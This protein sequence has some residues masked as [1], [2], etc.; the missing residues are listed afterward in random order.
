MFCRIFKTL[1]IS[2]DYQPEELNDKITENN[3]TFVGQH[4]R[5]LTSSSTA[6]LKCCKVNLC[7]D[8]MF[9]TAI[10]NPK[11]MPITYFLCFALLG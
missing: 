11:L 10:K 2:A 4:P 7:C 5:I 9:F 3:H 1:P 6:K 8:T